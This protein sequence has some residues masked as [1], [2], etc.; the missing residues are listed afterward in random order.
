MAFDLKKLVKQVS[1]ASADNRSG[2]IRAGE[3]ELEIRRTEIR[4][5]HKGPHFI[6]EFSVVS[7]KQTDPNIQ[8]NI[9]G[10]TVASVLPLQGERA[11][12]SANTIRALVEA[13]TKER[14]EACGEDIIAEFC[15]PKNSDTVKG[16]R[17]KFQAVQIKTKAGRDYTKVSF[18][19]AE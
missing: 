8:P 15:D 3:G 4:D 9:V 5:G 6:V 12:S 13:A 17:V 2:Y 7:A 18:Y 1:A 14:G 16:T 10:S 11:T 19:P